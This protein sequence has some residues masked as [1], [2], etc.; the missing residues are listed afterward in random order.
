MIGVMDN[1]IINGAH[2]FRNNASVSWQNPISP[3]FEVK[4][5]DIVSFS[6][7][8]QAVTGKFYYIR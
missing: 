4:K 5:G 8:A 7:K 3:I 2:V 6:G 1:I